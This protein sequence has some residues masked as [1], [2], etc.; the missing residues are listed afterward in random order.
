MYW[1]LASLPSSTR[2]WSWRPSRP[3]EPR[4]SKCTAAVCR[5]NEQSTRPAS[6]RC[7]R[8]PTTYVQMDDGVEKRRNKRERERTKA[9]PNWRKDE[10]IFL[11]TALL[12]L[13]PLPTLPHAFLDPLLPFFSTSPSRDERERPRHNCRGG[14]AEEWRHTAPLFFVTSISALK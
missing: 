5:S 4:S 11:P 9:L 14:L 13:L 3:S 1:A 12:Y 10:Q 8:T 6:P 7:C 2:S